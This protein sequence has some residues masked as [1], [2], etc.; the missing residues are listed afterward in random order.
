[1]MQLTIRKM[2]S[3]SSFS[4]QKT[5]LATKYCIV[6]PWAG[7]EKQQLCHILEAAGQQ[8]TDTAAAATA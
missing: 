5:F 3:Y 7:A 6:L 8:T 1:M 2:Q 4:L